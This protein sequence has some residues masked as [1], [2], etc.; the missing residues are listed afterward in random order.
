MTDPLSPAA[1]KIETSSQFGESLF[2]KS[3]RKFRRDKFGLTGL[4]VVGFY[5]LVAFLVW[6]G[7]FC[8]LTDSTTVV[9]P[10]HVAPGEVYSWQLD[11]QPM[12][13]YT[14][15]MGTDVQGFDV[16]TRLIYSIKQAF[17]IGLLVA[18]FSVFIGVVLGSIS[19][20]FPGV[21]DDFLLWVYTS[22]SSVPFILWIIAISY[23][24]GKGFVG[25][26]VALSC[27]FWL[28]IYFNIRAEVRKLKE[29]EFVLAS[30][31]FGMSKWRIIFGDILPNLSHL[32]FIFLS[33]NFIAAI[34]NEVILSFLGLGIAGEPSWGLMISNAR[35]D[36]LAGKWWEVTGATI[37]LFILVMAFNLFTDAL[38]DAFD[39]KK[40][41]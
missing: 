2:K 4:A 23:A 21:V 29:M 12:Q 34:K 18:F 28:G 15:R 17:S 9:G 25:V 27:T 35:T 11:G 37:L 14:S 26:V 30:E 22:I 10:Q 19:G 40:V 32:I 13:K 41:G 38:Q 5:G 16:Y 33:L 1:P 3:M 7:A 8:S 31:S 39:P 24:L 6:V 36:L 20:Y